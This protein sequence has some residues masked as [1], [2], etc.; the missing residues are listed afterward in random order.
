MENHTRLPKAQNT[1]SEMTGGIRLHARCIELVLLTLALTTPSQA[2]DRA[3]DLTIRWVD[4]YGLFDV[5]SETLAAQVRASFERLGAR[6]LWKD[7]PTLASTR[8]GREFVVYLRPSEPGKLGF[9]VQ[10]MGV[11]FGVDGHLNNIWIFF[12]TI[13]RAVDPRKQPRK[14]GGSTRRGPA[15]ETPELERLKKLAWLERDRVARAMSSV[16]VHE[17]IHAVAP[18]TAEHAAE[19]LMS[20]KLKEVS[21]LK[22][23]LPVDARAAQAFTGNLAAL[24][25]SPIKE[26]G[27]GGGFHGEERPRAVRRPAFS[28]TMIDPSTRAGPP[29][30]EAGLTFR[31][32]YSYFHHN[33]DGFLP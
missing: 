25:S 12:P 26:E 18:E 19:G 13:V 7:D 30:S 10:T 11:V 27:A 22:L 23:E 24:L 1:G 15:F 4:S 20:A 32:V 21:L 31:L 29:G 17:V 5:G 9:P 14:V 33:N 28:A 16:V 3:P 2:Q 8:E 6:L